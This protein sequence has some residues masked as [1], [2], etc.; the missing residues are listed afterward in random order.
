MGVLA[1][2]RSA[3]KPARHATDVAL[4]ARRLDLTRMA[5]TRG[6]SGAGGLKKVTEQEWQAEAWGYFDEVPE[7]KHGIWFLGNAMS[8]LRLFPTVYDP[9][10]DEDVPVVLLDAPVPADLAEAAIEEMNRL[11][12]TTGGLSEIIRELTMNLEVAGEC[13]LVGIGARPALVNQKGDVERDATDEEWDIKSVSEIKIENGRVKI[14][15]SPSDSQY[16]KTL[17]PELDSA[18]RIWLRHPRY[19]DVADSNLR[20]VLVD[21]K[22]LTTLAL[23][24]QAES[25]SRISNGAFTMPTEVQFKPADPTVGTEGGDGPEQDPFMSQLEAAMLDPIEDPSSGSAVVPLVIRGPAEFLQEK[26]I[27]HIDL[28]HT[29]TAA[30]LNALIEQHVMRVARGVNLPV[31]V[32]EGHMSTTFTNARQIDQ[33]IYDDRLDPRVRLIQ[34]ALELSY[35]RPN[36]IAR[37]F[38]PELVDLIGVGADPSDMLSKADPVENALALWDRGAITTEKLV[39]VLG[40]DEGDVP[41]AAE[42]LERVGLRRGIFTADLTVYLL[43]ELADEAG[44]ELPTPSETVPAVVGNDEVQG[45]TSGGGAASDQ[46]MDLLQ[47]AIEQNRAAT[48]RRRAI[49]ARLMPP[50]ALTA[51]GAVDGRDIGRRLTAID[52]DL[53]TRLHVAADDAMVRAL[54]KAGAR[55]RSKAGPSLRRQLAG[56]PVDRFVAQLG[57]DH[58]LFASNDPDELL[59][60]AWDAL[61]NQ[62]MSWGAVNQDA[63]LDLAAQLASGIS[64]ALRDDL[65]L[66]QADDLAQAWTWMEGAL[67]KRATDLLFDPS[68]PIPDIGEFSPHSR[69]PTGMVRE[70]MARAGGA[71]NVGYTETGGAYIVIGDGNQ[72]VG[73]IGTGEL[74]KG[75]LRDEGV[76]VEGYR[77]VYGPAMRTTEF[78]P[79]RNLDDTEFVNFDAEVLRNNNS[80]PAGEFYLPGD[81]SGCICD[82]EP[83]FITP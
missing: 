77:W 3:I 46:L 33:D 6:K 53:R 36:L 4:S 13:W 40:F 56:I 75:A 41:E 39:T 19:S 51:A 10:R 27:R 16:K 72:P 25:N 69:V 52:Q 79:H 73:G 80:F 78:I 31:E 11:R 38:D 12:S 43:Q 32:T 42:I 60:D 35:L 63:A 49:P 18:I 68:I 2:I 57:R 47:Q 55:A 54:E 22:V 67:Q 5:R 14:K 29:T 8:K 28:G 48:A 37:G 65:K 26:Y 59:A 30:E 70:A 34:D 50:A 61:E 1:G 76:G 24:V 7:L 44:V 23:R 9:D 17:N 66:R 45:P 64:G 82:V 58:P 20:G 83:I 81:H 15:T 62:F 21:C 71:T 74:V